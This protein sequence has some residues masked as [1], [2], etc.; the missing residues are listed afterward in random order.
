[1]IPIWYIA[2]KKTEK[3]IKAGLYAGFKASGKDFTLY[4]KESLF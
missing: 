1:M 2:R 4:K 3:T